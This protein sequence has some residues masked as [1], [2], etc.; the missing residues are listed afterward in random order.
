MFSKMASDSLMS[1]INIYGVLHLSRI[2]NYKE[3]VKLRIYDSW[4]IL[5]ELTFN[6]K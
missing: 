1:K 4:E 3:G 2:L 5:H 6:L